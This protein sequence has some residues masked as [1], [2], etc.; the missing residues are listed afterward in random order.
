MPTLIKDRYELLET[1]GAGGEA[2]SSRRS[3]ASTTGSSR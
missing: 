3:T 1:L 2:A